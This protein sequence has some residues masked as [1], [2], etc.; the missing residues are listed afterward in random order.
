MRRL[1]AGA[2]VVAAL[3]CCRVAYGDSIQDLLQRCNSQQ[4]SPNWLY[5][6]GQVG[7]VGD[8]MAV[9]GSLISEYG[10]KKG[11]LAI[12]SIC[13]PGNYGARAQAFKNW[14]QKH[15]EMWDQPGAAGAMIALHETWPCR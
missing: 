8:V 2:S 15:P 4:N 1:A 12:I 11:D 7:G 6:L 14:A 5:C 13:A 3:F 10:G 9:N